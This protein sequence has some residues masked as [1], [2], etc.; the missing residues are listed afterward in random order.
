MDEAIKDHVAWD[1]WE[2]WGAIMAQFFTQDM[3]YDTNY[4]DGTNVFMGN[5]TGIR[6]WYE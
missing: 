2:Q 1:D 6:S 5:G 3:I 4:Y